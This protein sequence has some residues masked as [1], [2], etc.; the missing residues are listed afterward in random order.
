MRGTAIVAGSLI[1]Y[2]M[3][4]HVLS[5]LHWLAGLRDLG[6]DVVFAESYNWVGCWNPETQEMGEDASYGLRQMRAWS[7]A[8]GLRGWCY[9]DAHGGYHGL[10]REEMV[11]A[12]RHA[13]VLISLWTVT[14]LEEF[15][16]CRRRIFIDTDP[17]FT[18][19]SMPPEPSPSA[20]GYASPWDFHEHFTY[21]MRLGQPDCPF[22]TY[23]IEWKPIR[24]PVV[25]DFLP[26]R[27]TPDARRFTTVMSWNNRAPIVHD[28]VT[29]GQKD[30]EF[31]RIADLP[32]RVPECF[33]IA[34]AGRAPREEIAARGWRLA[35][36]GNVTATPWTYRDYITRSRGEFSVAVNLEVKGRS[37]WF[38]DRTAAYLA[39]GKP[40]IVQDTG[41][42][43]CLPCGRGLLPF[44]SLDDAVAA[45]QDVR[46]DYA[47]HCAAARVLA[48][49]YFD[50]RRV[51]TAVL[52]PQ[53]G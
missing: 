8:A 33:E 45:V 24:P 41:F 31:W 34:L 49:E 19:F 37:G 10:S 40:A 23:G 11:E 36:A 28:G 17:G 27:Y 43:E 47:G 2:P 7:A 20:I 48:E 5:I 35:W 29:Y 9:V 16:E 1:A 21:G 42:S 15:R 6:Y 46:R 39:S 18:Q 30:V 22:P 38:S 32:S 4:G 12:C 52:N 26:Y 13:E 44:S 53:K 3:G 14:W 50:A 25:L 51:L